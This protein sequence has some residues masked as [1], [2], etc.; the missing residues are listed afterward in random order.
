MFYSCSE[1]C[2][3][4]GAACDSCVLDRCHDPFAACQ[5]ATC[6]N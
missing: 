4:Y 1:E 3:T 6:A 2:A 5:A